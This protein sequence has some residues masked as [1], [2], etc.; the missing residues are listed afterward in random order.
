MRC[1]AL[2]FKMV[3]TDAILEGVSGDQNCDKIASNLK[4]MYNLRGPTIAAVVRDNTA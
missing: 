2:L 1:A 4:I 3:A